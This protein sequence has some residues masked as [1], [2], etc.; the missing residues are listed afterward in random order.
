MGIGLLHSLLSWLRRGSDKV[1][2]MVSS[3]CIVVNHDPNEIRPFEP[4]EIVVSTTNEQ[5]DC[6]FLQ[7]LPLEIR[8][9][10]YTHLWR[11]PYAHEYHQPNGRHI[12]YERGRW[13]SRQ[14]VMYPDEEDLNSIQN[15][16]DVAYEQTKLDN[17]QR[18]HAWLRSTWGHRHWRCQERMCRPATV[19]DKTDFIYMMLICKRMYPE[20]MQSIFE[21]K[22]FMFNDIISAHEFLAGDG[23]PFARHI[24][25]LELTFNLG[26][27][28]YQPFML[29][30]AEQGA[31]QD[32]LDKLSRHGLLNDIWTALGKMAC[33][34]NVR[35][36]FDVYDRGVWRKI[37]EKN[38]TSALKHLSVQHQFTIE[39]PPRLPIPAPRLE[40]QALDDDTDGKNP[41]SVLRRPAL[42]YWTFVPDKVERF[43]FETHLD[44]SNN[45]SCAIAVLKD[46]T[47]VHSSQAPYNNPHLL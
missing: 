9:I 19:V 41:F 35:I 3:E 23:M 25:D 37:P 1:E 46:A 24:R 4:T 44:D 34:H 32:A 21:S 45:E 38:I 16:M 27:H 2:T 26:Q 40:G 29:A 20:I 8:R 12:S 36:A 6:L 17:L 30:A 13:F 7:K 15:A 10:I 14:C 42:R 11:H 31:G 28:H 5:A 22:R 33:L 39:L 18:C 43:T 47:F